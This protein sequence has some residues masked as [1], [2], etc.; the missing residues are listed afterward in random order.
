MRAVHLAVLLPRGTPRIHVLD[1]D[2]HAVL[3]VRAAHT[4]SETCR[5][6]ALPTE[7][8]MH[9]DGADPHL[10]REQNG[11]LDL[12]PRATPHLLR[13]QQRGCVNRGHRNLIPLDQRVQFVARAGRGVTR[14]QDL[15]AVVTQVPSQLERPLRALRERARRRKIDGDTLR[16]RR[17]WVN[18]QRSS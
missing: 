7:R 18:R 11:T 13:E 16:S 15:D 2:H 10:V 14:Y 6:L 12:L 1:G 4:L 5:I 3:L 9:H 8:R 17:R